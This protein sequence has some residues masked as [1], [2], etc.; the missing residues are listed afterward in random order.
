MMQKDVD[1][2]ERF[3]VQGRRDR[4]IVGERRLKRRIGDK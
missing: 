3:M 4:D 1:A 2:V